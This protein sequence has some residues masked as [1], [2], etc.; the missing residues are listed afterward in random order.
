MIEVARTGPVELVYGLVGAEHLVVFDRDVADGFLEVV[1]RWKT[2]S[3][4][5]QAIDMAKSSYD[6][7]YD[8]EMLTYF[9]EDNEFGPDDEFRIA[10]WTRDGEW[11]GALPEQSALP[12]DWGLSATT[13]DNMVSS[14][15][16][17]VPVESETAL[18]DAAASAH[19]HLVR[20]DNFIWSLYDPLA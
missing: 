11:P 12:D 9:M 4:W 1:E 2:V 19:V 18:I 13:E 17:Y 8:D 6:G 10:D 20:D 3:T 14:G 5:A 16:D 15:F 7:P